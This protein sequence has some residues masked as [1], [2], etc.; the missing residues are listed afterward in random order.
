MELKNRIWMNGNLEWFTY[1]GNE[2]VFLGRRE[3]PYPLREGDR[4]TNG[5]GEVFRIVSGEITREF[6]PD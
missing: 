2:T 3:V 1:L 5:H 4:W 6:S